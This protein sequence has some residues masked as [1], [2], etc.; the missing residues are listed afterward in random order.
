MRVEFRHQQ[1]ERMKEVI[2]RLFKQYGNKKTGLKYHLPH[3]LL[4]ATIL[5]AQCTDKRVNQVT[6]RLFQKYKTVE[7]FANSDVDEL[8]GEIHSCGYHNQK[9]KAIKGAS[10]MIWEEYSGEMP[11]TL[12]ELVKFPGVG[13]K[14]A[15]CILGSVFEIPAVVIDTHMIRIMGLLGFTDSKNPEKIER[16]I[17][18][19]TPEEDWINLTHLIIDHG[20]QICIARRPNCGE[21]ILC[22]ICPS[23]IPNS[24]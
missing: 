18:D 23:S 17:M 16:E 8:A 6:P 7:D 5:S 10:L 13:R 3:Q 11:D 1:Q 22:D 19:I 4:I 9:A 20:R 14:T 12:D 24:F 2:Y 15:N 21:C